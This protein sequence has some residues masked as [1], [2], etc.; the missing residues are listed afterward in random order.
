V[1]AWLRDRGLDFHGLVLDNGS[2]LSRSG[3]ISASDLV[4]LLADAQGTAEQGERF[5]ESLP[6]VGE[7]GTVRYR[8]VGDP[9]AGHAWIKTGSLAD[10][11]AIAGYLEA[12]SG[13]RYALA[14]LV[15]G[16]RAAAATSAQDRLLHWLY[17]QG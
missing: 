3:R 9:V 8:L 5:R 7:T 16:P 10:V 6:R 1:L 17:A 13:R 14:M 4:R 11:R 12:A 15:N 2:G